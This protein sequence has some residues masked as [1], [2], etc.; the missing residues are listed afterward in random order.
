MNQICFA[1]KFD[2]LRIHIM[3][4]RLMYSN[5]C[6][7]WIC[8]WSRPDDVS[9]HFLLSHFLKIFL[10]RC[11]YGLSLV[12][13]L[14]WF[15]LHILELGMCLCLY[16][17]HSCRSCSIGWRSK[18]Q[19]YYR[20]VLPMDHLISAFMQFSYCMLT[21]VIACPHHWMNTANILCQLWQNYY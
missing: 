21:Q 7:L 2:L 14:S 13:I 19:E 12:P 1:S 4:S 3:K 15:F 10:G 5:Q 18:R 11:A 20:Y 6:P 17:I 8:S 16:C 9:F